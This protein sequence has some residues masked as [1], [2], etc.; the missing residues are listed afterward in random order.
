MANWLHAV[1]RSED[2]ITPMWSNRLSFHEGGVYKFWGPM[3]CSKTRA[4]IATIINLVEHRHYFGN[5]VFANCWLDI[6]GSHWLS[7]YELKKVLRRAFNT[8]VGAGRWN[9]CIFAIMEADDLYS[10]ITQSDKECFQDLLKASQSMKRNQHLLYEVHEGRA[11]PK[12]MRDKT[13]IS[14]RPVADDRHDKL[15][16]YVCN[17]QYNRTLIVPVENISSVNGRYRRFD[18]LV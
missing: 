10:H 6:P 12:F 13:E 2:I 4:M 14:V 3:E 15:Y 7:N 1:E 18:V 9:K 5:R 11:V 8:E 17:G 16:L